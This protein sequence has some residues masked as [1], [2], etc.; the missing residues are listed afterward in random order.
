LCKE[1][2]YSAFETEIHYTIVKSKLFQP[3]DFVAIGASGGKVSIFLN[4]GLKVFGHF[5]NLE[6]WITLEP[7][8]INT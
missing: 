4:L 6:L 3:G 8:I 1:C 5:S 7:K 2:F